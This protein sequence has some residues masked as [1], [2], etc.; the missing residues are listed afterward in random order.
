MESL[1]SSHFAKI[2]NLLNA[3]TNFIDQAREIIY[4]VSGVNLAAAELVW[5]PPTL[6]IKSSPPARNLILRHRE[7]ILTRLT[8]QFDRQAPRVIR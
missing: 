5:R 8:A 3:R 1:S 4:Q 6:T 7:K 2:K